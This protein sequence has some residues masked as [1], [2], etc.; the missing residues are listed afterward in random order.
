M[1]WRDRASGTRDEVD[2]GRRRRRES[3]VPARPEPA[4]LMREALRRNSMLRIPGED[5]EDQR[6]AAG[7]DQEQA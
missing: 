7:A 4:P 3:A 2:A 5:R 1:R 6:M